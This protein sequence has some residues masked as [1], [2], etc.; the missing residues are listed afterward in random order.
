MQQFSKG[1][2]TQQKYQEV[3]ITGS[4]DSLPQSILWLPLIN[5]HPI[6]RIYLLRAPKISCYYNMSSKS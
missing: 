5:F 3:D 6:Y 2:Y 4:N 1:D